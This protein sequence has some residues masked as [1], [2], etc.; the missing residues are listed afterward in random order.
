LKHEVVASLFT[1]RALEE[2]QGPAM[3]V[4][5]RLIELVKLVLTHLFETLPMKL[6]WDRAEF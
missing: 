4:G 2:C 3:L 6:V 1:L 5:L